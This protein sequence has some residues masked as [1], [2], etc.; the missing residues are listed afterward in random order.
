MQ[1]CLEADTPTGII[2]S[3]IDKTHVYTPWKIGLQA[4]VLKGR[5]IH[6]ELPKP[7]SIR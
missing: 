1:I 6:R 2:N 3:H 4:D 7:K 5:Q